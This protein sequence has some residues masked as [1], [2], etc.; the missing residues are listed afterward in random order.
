MACEL[1]IEELITGLNNFV[2]NTL[3]LAVSMDIAIE[4]YDRETLVLSA[5]LEKNINDKN[6]AFGGSLYVLN[7]MTCWGMVYMKCREGGIEI[8]NIVV[9]HAEID[10]LAPVPDKKIIASC[11]ISDDFDGFI[12][13][14][15]GNGRSRV[16]LQSS[17]VTAGKTAVLFKGKYAVIE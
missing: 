10:Y 7:V 6:T 15:Y 11:T 1:S 3:D 12:E 8:P 17:V 5:P 2:I 4:S 13:Y 16:R 14:Y 9:S